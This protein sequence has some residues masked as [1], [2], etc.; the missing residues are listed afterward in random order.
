MAK[1]KI[2][3]REMFYFLG[4]SILIAGILWPLQYPDA[5]STLFL[6]IVG[7]ILMLYGWTGMGE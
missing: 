6:I 4:G 3:D 2:L 5:E 1:G 7:A